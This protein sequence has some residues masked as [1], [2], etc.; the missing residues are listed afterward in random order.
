MF[1]SLKFPLPLCDTFFPENDG[2][3]DFRNYEHM[4]TCFLNVRNCS[5]CILYTGLNW[6]FMVGE[7]DF[8]VSGGVLERDIFL[9]LSG[10]RQ[11]FFGKDFP[12]FMLI[13]FV[14]FQVILT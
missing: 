5:L 3:T 6:C 8:F 11:P 14:K 1:Y 7:K 2:K 4:K 13:S 9:S 12:Q 10:G